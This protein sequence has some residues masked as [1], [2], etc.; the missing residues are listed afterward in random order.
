MTIAMTIVFPEP[1]AILQHWRANAPP[2]PGISSPTCSAAGPSVSQIK[3]LDGFNW[4]KKKRRASNFLPG[5]AS[6]PQAP[7]DAAHAR[8]ARCTPGRHARADLVDQRDFDEDAGIVEGLGAFGRHHV[9][10]RA[11][12]LD[13]V[14]QARLALV[15]PG[16]HRLLV[17]RID[18]QAVNRGLRHQPAS[19]GT[20]GH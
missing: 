15:A 5:R 2:S 3:R 13:Q 8:I 14:E 19:G 17:R 7:S 18:D 11:A 4:Q 6:V 10:R 9:A 16:A 20:S 1:V 12:A